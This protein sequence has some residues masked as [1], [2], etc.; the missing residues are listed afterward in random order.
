MNKLHG[1]VSVSPWIMNDTALKKGERICRNNYNYK[2]K[3]KKRSTH[4]KKSHYT[5][6]DHSKSAIHKQLFLS[7]L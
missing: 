4:A 3:A 2:L 7:T 1:L 5:I 6:S